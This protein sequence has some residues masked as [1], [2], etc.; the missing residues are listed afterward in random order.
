MSGCHIVVNHCWSADDPWETSIAD[1]TRAL[2][3]IPLLFLSLVGIVTISYAFVSV[4]LRLL[5]PLRGVFPLR[6]SRRARGEESSWVTPGPFA[7]PGTPQPPQLRTPGPA[8][9]PLAAPLEPLT[10][11]FSDPCLQIPGLRCRNRSPAARDPSRPPRKTPSPPERPP[12]RLRHPPRSSAEVYAV[13]RGRH[14]SLS[15][16]QGSFESSTTCSPPRRAVSRDVYALR[17][18]RDLK[19]RLP[20]SP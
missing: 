9:T 11:P 17:R 18:R 3:A 12:P 19:P 10:Q 8:P 13:V 20:F 2:G 7:H 15:S 1:L 6:W 14:R 4:L 16:P 5:A